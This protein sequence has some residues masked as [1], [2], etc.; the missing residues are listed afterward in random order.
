[1]FFIS[2]AGLFDLLLKSKCKTFKDL[3]KAV[4]VSAAVEFSP[5]KMDQTLFAKMTLLG[6]FRKIDLKTVFMY[7]LD[8]LPWS[9]ADA[10][11][12]L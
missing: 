4:K 9:L 6:K 7:P 11:G 1:M 3:K 5:L 8:F 2:Q 10:Y 12:L